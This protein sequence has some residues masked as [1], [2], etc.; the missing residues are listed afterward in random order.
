VHPGRRLFSNKLDQLPLRIARR[1][2]PF[3][4]STPASQMKF[5][6]GSSGWRAALTRRCFPGSPAPVGMHGAILNYINPFWRYGDRG[7][8][9]KHSIKRGR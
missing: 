5:M 9:G 8:V 2:Q 7:N 1:L 4:G 3:D 6:A